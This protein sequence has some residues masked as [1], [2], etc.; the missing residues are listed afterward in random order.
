MAQEILIIG[1]SGSGKS[2]SLEYL[3]PKSTF[4]VNV[5]KKPMPFRGWKNNYS[6]LTKENPKGNYIESDNAAT[7]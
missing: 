2:T 3:D 1:E 4:V 6:L 5:G 7:I